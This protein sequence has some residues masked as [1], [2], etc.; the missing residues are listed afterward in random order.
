MSDPRNHHYIPQFW[1]KRFSHDGQSKLVWSYDWD[2]DT[3]QERSI[4]TLMSEYDLYT[5]QTSMGDDFSLET[6]EMGQVDRAGSKLFRRIDQG[7]RSSALREDLA[8]FFAVMALRHPATV[9][10]FP[11]VTANFLG[12]LQ[13]VL[14]GATSLADLDEYLASIG[15]PASGMTPAVFA[16][17]K[18]ATSA[19]LDLFFTTQFDKQLAPGGNEAI[20]YADTIEDHSGRD[21]LK[22]RLLDM[23]WTLATAPEATV[24]IGD[25][26]IVLERGNSDHGWKIVIGP[27]LV[28]SITKTEQSVPVMIGSGTLTTWE[29]DGLNL[30]T[31]AR[32]K[33][34]LVGRSKAA[35]VRASAQ[36]KGGNH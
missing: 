11:V 15:A 9:S 4:T 18:S 3:V 25:T 26:G 16:A 34:L 31:A 29:V 36:I 27:Q 28:L 22:D 8:D 12:D 10:R 21:I 5:Q 19:D 2:K 33:K 7:E 13:S 23:E 14:V 32:S 1:L 17:I 35:I 24:L 20:P 6:G 30:E